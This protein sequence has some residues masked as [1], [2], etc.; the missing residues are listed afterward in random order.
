[1]LPPGPRDYWNLLAAEHKAAPAHQN[2]MYE[3]DPFSARKA[4]QERQEKAAKRNEDAS[5]SEIGAKPASH[6][7]PDFANVPEAKMA[8]SLRDLVEDA[9]K[10]A[11]L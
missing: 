9:V 1:M 2:W 8:S 11:S 5:G 4:V 6:S 7:P 3:A 10:K